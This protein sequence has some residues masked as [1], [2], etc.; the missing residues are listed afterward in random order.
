MNELTR[1]HEDIQS[2]SIDAIESMYISIQ[3]YELTQQYSFP[4][5]KSLGSQNSSAVVA[6][7]GKSFITQNSSITKPE[8]AGRKSLSKFNSIL[9]FERDS[10]DIFDERR[11]MHSSNRSQVPK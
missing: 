5:K 9:C 8:P 11:H 2:L 7:L 1:G 4:A 10:F 6:A 3:R